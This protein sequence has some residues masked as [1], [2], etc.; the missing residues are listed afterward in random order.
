VKKESETATTI[1]RNGGYLRAWA[2]KA[3]SD[4]A[5]RYA[6]LVFV[7][8]RVVI[9][10]WMALVLTVTRVPTTPDE[11]LRPYQG[12]EPI[13]GGLAEPLL[14]VWQRFDTLWYVKIAAQGYSP[15]N[16]SAVYFPLYPLL[17]RPLGQIFMGDYLLAALF[18][19]NLAYIGVLFYLYKLT[20]ME[21]NRPAARRSVA[22]LAIFPTAFFFL[23]AYTES[24]FL[25]LTLAAFYYAKE[26]RWWLAG[27]LG[28]LSSLTRLQGIVLI[29]PLLYMYLRD[30]AFR[31]SRLRPDILALIVIPGG[32][33]LFLAC[34]HLSIGS[35]PLLATYQTQ[36]HALFVLPWDNIIATY[37]K[38]LSPEGTFIN[39]LNLTVTCLFLAMTA[40]SFR[41][42]PLDYGIY[43]VVTIFVLLL[44]RTTLQ[45]LVSMSRYVLV[46]FPA[47]MMWGHWG[48]NPRF[49]RLVVYPS[50][51]LLLYLSGQFAM[52]GWVA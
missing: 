25:F 52:W 19:S 12:I 27:A 29:I 21:F 43:M 31:L 46:L 42:L 47:F 8:T 7:V 50:V 36:L 5:L 22:Y 17:I 48:R 49:Q 13:S 33:A 9:S 20:E 34:Q 28:F 14:G 23:A 38:V 41:K 44:R 11:I 10:L 18:I 4:P 3:I 15:E 32:A 30:R 16:E 37:Q 6:I 2:R 1:T 39:V 24:L 40:L 45:P 51:A 35:T 26:K